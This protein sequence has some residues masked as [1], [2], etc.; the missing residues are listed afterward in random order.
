M[1]GDPRNPLCEPTMNILL[2]QLPGTSRKERRTDMA[3]LF[4]VL[5]FDFWPLTNEKV[6]WVV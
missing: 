6:S 3:I 5:H 1:R 2:T 4:S